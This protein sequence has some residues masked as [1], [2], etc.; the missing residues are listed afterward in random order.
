MPV[1]QV[2]AKRKLKCIGGA[3]SELSLLSNDA[4]GPNIALCLRT[5][6]ELQYNTLSGCKS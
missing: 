2:K 6:E 3:V 5:A 1:P 4:E